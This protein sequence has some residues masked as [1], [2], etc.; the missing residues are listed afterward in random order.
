MRHA[1]AADGVHTM[2][3]QP[4]RS[5]GGAHMVTAMRTVKE[6]FMPVD[7]VFLLQDLCY[8]GT[9]RQTLHI[10]A[11]LDRTRF[12]P[13]IWTLSGPTDLDA[14]AEQAAIGL[15]HLGR[16][17]F[18]SPRFPLALLR[19]LLRQPPALLVPCTQLPNIWGRLLGRLTGVRAL[20]G[21]CRGGGAPARQHER[22]LWRL[23]DHMICNSR[24]LY[25]LL[26]EFGCP[27][28]R[29]SYIPNG[30][31]T[32]HF[33]PG[34]LPPAQ[35]DPEIVC[36]ARLAR[37][38]DHVTLLRAF[39]QVLDEYPRARLRLVGEGPEEAAL[40]RSA[41]ALSLGDAVIFSGAS[42]NPLPF[43]QRA[44][45]MAL[46]SRQEAQPN[47]ILEAMACGLPVVATAVGG[48]PDLV[49]PASGRLA[50]AGDAAALARHFLALL[51]A[52]EE[53]QALGEAGRARVTAEFSFATTVRLH[54]E[55]FA[56]LAP[57]SGS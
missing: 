43:Y 31:A 49:T 27:P 40:R 17:R 16:G 12:R 3:M 21:T 23:T 9:Q 44:R 52:P 5:G 33:V 18:P 10:A 50:P 39:R 4:C 51:R 28:E 29:V 15:T 41:A 25:R 53:A 54:E 36:V 47:V 32:E 22:W 56:R 55:I 35:R 14:E 24:H 26:Q 57:G 2:D 34:A 8:G 45:I 11:R 13:H 37:D 1:S 6:K 7:I 38:K 48:I 42:A 20:V 30:I 19:Q 46:T